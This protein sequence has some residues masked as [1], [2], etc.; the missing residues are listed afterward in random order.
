[1]AT[2]FNTFGTTSGLATESTLSQVKDKLNDSIDVNLT[3]DVVTVKTNIIEL[4][5]TPLAAA[6]LPVNV[7]NNISATI[8][9]ATPIDVNIS[10]NPVPVQVNN[11][12]NIPVQVNNTA[13]IPTSILDA[14]LPPT[15]VTNTVSTNLIQINGSTPSLNQSTADIGTLRT[16]L[17]LDQK[18]DF[19]ASQPMSIN[20]Q[21]YP[22]IMHR[23]S[24]IQNPTSSA[25]GNLRLWDPTTYIVGNL[26]TGLT[27]AGVGPPPATTAA[28]LYYIQSTSPND[29]DTTPSGLRSVI[30]LAYIDGTSE[31]PTPITA[32]LNG[33]TASNIATAFHRIQDIFPN[34]FAS[35]FSYSQGDIQIFEQSNNRPYP[36]RMKAFTNR[37]N[38][39]Y[40]YIPPCTLT[41]YLNTRIYNRVRF[42]YVNFTI[43]NTGG[44]EEEIQLWVK[45]NAGTFAWVQKYNFHC[46]NPSREQLNLSNV[47]FPSDAGYDAVLVFN[48]DTAQGS[49]YG[50]WSVGAHIE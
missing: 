35:G 37:W 4:N 13:P 21:S 32:V 25:A 44:S 28:T 43:E 18:Y 16:T 30:I 14:T 15:T 31:S 20:K 17:A 40:M 23:S 47:T 41:S 8:T 38:S 7:T 39:P 11:F 45:K 19:C 49:F 1:M 22:F 3:G 24:S 48:R 2:R 12:T 27:F 6:E 42:D 10:T 36:G 5:N 29:S 26:A 46:N 33:T 50:G 9:N 34:E